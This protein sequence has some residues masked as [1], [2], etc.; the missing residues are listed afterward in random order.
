[1]EGFATYPFHPGVGGSH[2]LLRGGYGEALALGVFNVSF[3]TITKA[4]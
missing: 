4:I 1:L 3:T 2:S